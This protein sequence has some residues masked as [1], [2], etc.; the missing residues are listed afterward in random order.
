MPIYN[1]TRITPISV[2]PQ[3]YAEIPYP[4]NPKTGNQAKVTNAFAAESKSCF[5]FRFF[6]R[7]I[8]KIVNLFRLD[9]NPSKHRGRRKN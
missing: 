4:W 7:Q 8:E 5:L 3:I 2:Q 9:G 1:K 6:T